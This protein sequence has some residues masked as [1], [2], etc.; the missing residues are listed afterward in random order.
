MS[1]TSEQLPVSVVIAAH[2][3]GRVIEDCLAALLAQA[4]PQVA[5]VIVVAY[6]VDGSTQRAQARFPEVRWVRL[7]TP[8]TLAQMRGRG[9][10]LAQGAIIAILDP[11]AIVAA[12]WLAE[13]RRAHGEHPNWVIGGAVD[14]EGAATRTLAEWAL[15]L[16]EYGLFMPPVT[17]GATE[18]LPGCNLSYKRAALFEGDRP[19]YPEFWKTFANWEAEHH[20]ALWLAPSVVVYLNKPIPFGEFLASRL[21]HG[22]C[23]AGMRT[24]SAGWGERLARG[25]TTPL[26]PWLFLWRWGRVIWAK[27]RDRTRW[28]ATLPLQLLLFGSWA[29]GEMVGYLRGAG[30]SCRRLYY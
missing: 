30:T 5:E 3:A 17:C 19:K 22:R 14:L 20:S 4:Q 13:L 2:N 16:Y 15:Y 21:A 26:L 25:V 6:A 23:F 24:A 9:I 8:A 10:A 29:L 27:R 18:I 1:S 12:N 11:Y 28:L 7:D